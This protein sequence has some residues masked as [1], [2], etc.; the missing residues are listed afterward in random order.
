VHAACLDLGLRQLPRP[1]VRAVLGID[2]PTYASVHTTRAR[3]S[4]SG[5]EVVHLMRYEPG[6][7]VGLGEL[8]RI[9]DEI[10]PGWR[11]QEAARQVGQRRVVATDR[12]RP[13][14]GMA[15]RP[16]VTVDDAPGL[17]V[18]GDWVGPDDLLGAA[19]IASGRA[20]GLAAARVAAR[21]ATPAS[22]SSVPPLPVP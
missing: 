14:A 11:E 22:T 2:R 21:G 19:A 8:E 12:P 1:S 4:D 20:A 13:G 9:A 10:Q 18:A 6:E 15:G 7:D 16:A 5:G 3:L 17:H